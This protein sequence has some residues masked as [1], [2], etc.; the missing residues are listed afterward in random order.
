[1]NR[2][3][4]KTVSTT[5]KLVVSSGLRVLAG[6][7][8][9]H[10]GLGF[11]EFLDATWT[12]QAEQAGRHGVT[13][14]FSGRAASTPATATLSFLAARSVEKTDY[15]PPPHPVQTTVDIAAYYFPGWESPAKWDC[16]RR[17]APVRKPL[18]GF[19][20]EGNPEC[21]DWQ[22]KWA[23]ENG[24]G[25]YLVDWYWIQ[26][27]Q[28]LTH[29]FEAYRKARYRDQLRVAI[30]WANHNPPHTH[31]LEDW[32]NVTREWIDK[33]FTLS[34]Y[35]RIDGKPAVFIWNPEGIRNDL[36]GVEAVR[37]AL[38][39]SRRM[40]REAGY[41]GIAFAVVNGA[42]SPGLITMLAQEGYSGA[43]NYHEWGAVTDN[44]MGDA[45]ASFEEVARTAPT[46]WARRDAL[47]K[48]LVYYPLVETGW[49]AR[50]WHGEKSLVIRDRTPDRFE[51]LLRAA[52]EFGE[53]HTK[54]LIVLGPVNEWGE[55]SYIE[56]CTDF[57]FEMLEAVRRAFAKGEPST[58]PENIAPADVGRGPYDFPRASR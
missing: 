57:D 52:K 38:D 55:G 36:G 19:Y 5:P 22:I 11:N 17:I 43:T 47:C 48:P 44:A 58:W 25:T 46:E 42:D 24:I 28:H 31:S 45:R 51:C 34:S 37:A 32:R 7:V 26:G 18:L 29:W 41:P 39:E 33:Y 10:R 56:P 50:P 3:A 13:V 49:D 27:S 53:A 40:A 6:P 30:M 20:D 9:E 54:P 1:M 21:V 35:Y 12:V 23:V 8:F 15:V 4:A 16:I 2:G 14:K